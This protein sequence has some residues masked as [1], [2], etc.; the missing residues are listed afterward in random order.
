[1]RAANGFSRMTRKSID[2]REHY[3]FT[4]DKCASALFNPETTRSTHQ[5]SAEGQ[6]RIERREVKL[7]VASSLSLKRLVCS[8]SVDTG[9]GETSDEVNDRSAM[10]TLGGVFPMI[11]STNYQELFSDVNRSLRSAECQ[12]NLRIE[13]AR[14]DVGTHAPYVL[15]N[16]FRREQNS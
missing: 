5:L 6:G 14:D 7:S 11:V 13:K 4:E 1:M 2:W 15:P 3:S 12:I 16:L 10:E 9:I 8:P